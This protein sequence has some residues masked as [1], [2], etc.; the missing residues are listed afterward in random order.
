MKNDIHLFNIYLKVLLE[1]KAPL[2]PSEIEAEIKGRELT[3]DIV[4][5]KSSPVQ[6]I[7]PCKALLKFRPHG[8]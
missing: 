6:L 4:C 1:N 8:N 7:H 3:P 5:Y 2:S